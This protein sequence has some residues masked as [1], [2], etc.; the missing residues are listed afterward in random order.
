[1]IDEEEATRALLNLAGSRRNPSD[2]RTARVRA[3]VLA[4]WQAAR[5]QRRR[6][7]IA[8]ATG[9]LAAA[10]LVVFVVWARLPIVSSRGERVAMLDR[11]QGTP[12]VQAA[13][14]GA[15]PAIA[16]TTVLYGGDV[17]TTDAGDRAAIHTPDGSSVRIDERSRVRLLNAAVIE[18]E[19]GAVYIATARGAH[20]FEVRTALGTMRDLGTQ[21]EVRLGNG[22]LRLRVRSGMV[23]ISRHAGSTTVGAEMEAEVRDTG[24][25]LRPMAASPTD[26]AWTADLAPPFEIEGRPLQLFLDYL[27]AERGWRVTYDDRSAHDAA[28]ASVLHGSVAG[29]SADD[30]LRVV[31]GASGLSYQLRGNELVILRT[32]PPQ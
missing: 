24:L 20:G 22:A 31:L 9:L 1:M 27:S 29:L 11:I 16:E 12:V 4:E 25:A 23:E 32:A 13:Q 3:A 2:A 19:D 18:V 21:F 15:S 6:Q 26:W 30:A 8:I 5:R 14:G 10:A 7:R 28:T 17:I